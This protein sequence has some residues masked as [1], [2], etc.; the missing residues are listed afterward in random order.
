MLDP[1]Q[2][3]DPETVTLA[4]CL[5]EP[6]HRSLQQRKLERRG[7]R[8]TEE[9]VALAVQRG[10][11]Q[12]QN[13][14]EVPLI[15]KQE[16][17][18]EKLA[19]LLLSGSQSYNPR[20]IRAGAQ[21]LSDPAIN[22]KMLVFEAAKE[23]ALLPLAYIAQCGQK[24]EP[25]NPFWNRLLREIEANPRNRNWKPIAP[26]LL[27]HPSRFTLQMGYRAGRKCAST[28]WLRPMH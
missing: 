2:L 20:L 16:L 3:A 26:G 13:G 12:Y 14:I 5:G 19:A 23:R 17:P 11:I 7:I 1:V 27:P 6:T 9:L 10:C 22:L 28:V 15:P 25:D 8:T 4:R 24:V 18:N 21:L